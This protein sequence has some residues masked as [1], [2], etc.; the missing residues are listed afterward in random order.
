[1]NFLNKERNLFGQRADDIFMSSRKVGYFGQLPGELNNSAT[2]LNKAASRLPHAVSRFN[3]VFTNPIVFRFRFFS[4][5]FLVKNLCIS[6]KQVR[7][8]TISYKKAHSSN[9]AHMIQMKRQVWVLVCLIWFLSIFFE[10]SL[11]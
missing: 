1:M 2:C 6:L 11:R 9:E 7:V 10:N 8:P 3:V 4:F 5:F